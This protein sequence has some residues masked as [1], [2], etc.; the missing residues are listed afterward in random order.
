MGCSNTI[1]K[2]SRLAKRAIKSSASYFAM[3]SACGRYVNCRAMQ[4][5]RVRS[6]ESGHRADIVDR[7]KMTLAV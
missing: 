4:Q 3:T 1:Y 6:M 5:F 7:S 2:N